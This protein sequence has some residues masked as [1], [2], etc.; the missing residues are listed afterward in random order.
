[1]LPIGLTSC[2][3]YTLGF[4][5]YC[6]R[7]VIIAPAC[8]VN[9]NFL[10]AYGFC[11][12]DYRAGCYWW[13]L[14]PL[15]TAFAMVVAQALGGSGLDQLYLQFCIQAVYS[16][17][18]VY[19]RPYKHRINNAL[20]LILKIA[21]LGALLLATLITGKSSDV[22][23]YRTW[24]YDMMLL[25]ILTSAAAL[26]LVLVAIWIIQRTLGKVQKGSLKSSKV[27]ILLRTKDIVLDSCMMPFKEFVQLASCL[28]DEDIKEINSACQTLVAV[29]FKKQY[30]GKFGQQRLIQGKRREVWD[31]K[32]CTGHVLEVASSGP[33]LENIRGTCARRENLFIFASE[34]QE[35]CTDALGEAMQMTPQHNPLEELAQRVSCARVFADVHSRLKQRCLFGVVSKEAFCRVF[36]APR[37]TLEEVQLEEIFELVDDGT[38]YAGAEDL[39]RLINSAC[40]AVPE[41]VVNRQRSVGEQVFGTM[42]GVLNRASL[43]WSLFQHRVS[44]QDGEPV[45]AA[46][47]EP[48]DSPK[49][50]QAAVKAKVSSYVDIDNIES[51]VEDDHSEEKGERQNSPGD[52]EELRA[53]L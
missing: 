43:R 10:R 42:Q 51:P 16:F 26:G 49:E 34:L 24:L 8:A 28:D 37:T 18:L 29:L 12:D 31:A 14:V 40:E 13:I 21:I 5:C 47:S 48:D 32:E 30:T 38:G 35:S 27:D 11:F 41:L 7:A 39:Q 45:S 4:L 1:M 33:L 36:V 46:R 15:M 17:L 23:Q 9:P 53:S 3:F 25:T 6:I 44:K 22:R 50:A 20:E 52:D 2:A 19:N